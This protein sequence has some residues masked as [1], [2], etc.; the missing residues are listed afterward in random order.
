M[1]GE[2]GE[3]MVGYS[4]GKCSSRQFRG[5][6]KM[7]WQHAVDGYVFSPRMCWIET[8]RCAVGDNALES[9]HY[10]SCPY[11][12]GIASIDSTPIFAVQLPFCADLA[13]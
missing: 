7:L 5:Y 6:G 3:V 8:A 12:V 2:V 4:S 1:L 9:C 11:V 10:G 13:G